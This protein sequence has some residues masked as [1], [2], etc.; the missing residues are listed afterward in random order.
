MGK[1][2]WAWG[3]AGGSQRVCAECV[4]SQAQEVTWALQLEDHPALLKG[5]ESGDL[6]WARVRVIL[7]GILG[8][9]LDTARLLIDELISDAPQLTTGQLRSLVTRLK[10][11]VDP[12]SA[13]TGLEQEVE[14]RR[15]V[16]QP[17]PAGAASMA[18]FGLRPELAQAAWRRITR[19]AKKLKTREET[20]SLDQLR[21]DLFLGL[22]LGRENSAV[23]NTGVGV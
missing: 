18:G 21:A 3:A 12:E 2:L 23:T 7:E 4:V 5:L 16:C 15:V 8:M 1:W 11:T 6:D 14:E 17:E 9:N 22:L 19:M 10:I 20:R 13:R